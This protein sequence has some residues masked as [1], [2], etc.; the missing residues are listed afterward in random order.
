MAGISRLVQASL[1]LEHFENA[2]EREELFVPMD[3]IS[4]FVPGT[5][6][7]GCC[8]PWRDID[9]LLDLFT[10]LQ[11]DARSSQKR[12]KCFEYMEKKCG[13]NLRACCN[14]A[15]FPAQ[16]NAQDLL[17]NAFNHSGTILAKP[18]AGVL[19]IAPGPIRLGTEGRQGVATDL[20]YLRPISLAEIE[21]SFAV[22]RTSIRGDM[23]E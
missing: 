3:T 9:I 6:C 10:R 20:P 23:D 21:E 22:D 17:R 13:W 12:L 19:S 1:I 8:R 2:K 7:T 5:Y 14:R 18:P 11:K 15:L 4:A 16:R